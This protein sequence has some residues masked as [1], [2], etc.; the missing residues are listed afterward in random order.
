MRA[1]RVWAVAWR[2]LASVH[3]G[4]SRWGLPLLALGLLLPVGALPL[5]LE[6]PVKDPTV[7]LRVAGEIPAALAGQLVLDPA[8]PVRLEGQDPVRVVARAIPGPLRGKLDTLG[9]PTVRVEPSPVKLRLPGRSLLV[10]LLA[11]SLLTG[12]L[13]ESL[14]GERSR[15][16]L[17]VLL[18]AAI[19][20]A[21]LVAGKWLAWTMWGGGAS[22]LAALGGLLS[23]A[24]A[25]G[26]WPLA[27]PL[28]SGSAVA[29]GLWLVRGAADVVGGAAIPMRVV[30][31]L[32]IG[33]AGLAWGLGLVHPWLGAAVPLGGALLVAGAVWTGP[34]PLVAAALGSGLGTAALL[35][36]TAA[37]IDAQSS[38]ARTTGRGLVLAAAGLWWLPVAGPGVWAVAGNP[39]FEPDV[40][41]GL[42]AGGLCLLLLASVASAR[43]ARAPE[44]GDWR[45]WWTGAAGAALLVA[46]S[47]GLGGLSW[48]GAAPVARL[49]TG[50]GGADGIGLVAV[51]LGQE[52]VFRDLLRR[53]LGDAGALAAWIAVV[54]LA[55]P[56]LGLWSGLVLGGLA[57]RWGLGAAMLASLGW[58]ALG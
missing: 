58:A 24:Q 9:G 47:W 45:G 5:R 28:V 18:T 53:R 31:A 20:R 17:E 36:R 12:P 57:R 52:W 4:R 7:E 14:P 21:E 35:W 37:D 50:L 48:G 11:I 54:G 51:A 19:S 26:L 22:L 55:N 27:L 41:T 29:L 8:A 46:G 32:A 33:L 25:P 10:A 30:P 42:A 23:G 34:G 3:A 2:D 40:P 43:E 44:L 13:A 15:G 6:R 49:A 56:A 39:G 38:A 16:T 1:R